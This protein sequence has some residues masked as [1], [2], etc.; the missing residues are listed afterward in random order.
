ML[1]RENFLVLDWLNCGVVVVL[2]N[3]TINYTGMFLV[4]SRGYML[5]LNSR[6]DTLVDGSVVLSILVEKLADSCLGLLHFSCLRVTYS[7]VGLFVR[8]GQLRI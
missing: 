2:M 6:V 8:I 3:L 5:I 1:L 7:C 4:M